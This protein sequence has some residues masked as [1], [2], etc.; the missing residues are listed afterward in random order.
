M[1][2][3]Y[4]NNPT[5]IELDDAY[6]GL[7]KFGKITVKTSN[8][9]LSIYDLEKEGFVGI[10]VVGFASEAYPDFTI[11]AFKG[12]HGPCHFTGGKAKYSGA[13]F[14]ALDD[15]NHLLFADKYQVVCDKTS[16]IYALPPY[17]DLIDC[18]EIS[19][20]TKPGNSTIEE[21]SGDF[22]SNQSFLYNQ[23]KDQKSNSEGRKSLFYPGPFRFLILNDGT[24]VRRGKWNSIP[25]S[26][27]GD[28]IR[29][30]RFIYLEGKP[31]VR[32]AFFQEEYAQF[33]S[34]CLLDDFKPEAI[35]H[36]E[37]ETDFSKLA[38]VSDKF[39]TRLLS[40]INNRKKHFILIGNDASDQ[41]G[42]CPSEEVTDA[43]KLVKYGILDALAEPVQGDSCPVTMY[44]FKDEISINNDTLSSEI[45]NKFRKKVLS[46][47][48]NSSPSGWKKAIKWVLL[49]FI[50]VSLILAAI[51]LYNMQNAVTETSMYELL[52]PAGKNQALVVLFHNRKRCFQCTRMENLTREVLA[53]SYNN[54]LKNKS[55]GFETIIID[56]PANFGIVNQYG[57]Y[58]VTVVF[59]KFDQEEVV[60]SKV[61]TEATNLYRD[62]P[63]YKN[64]LKK[65]LH[66]F[67]IGV[68]D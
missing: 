37:I 30:D 60:K 63:V 57:I 56:D 12:K 6:R 3:L 21:E 9:E 50:A 14:A 19:Q 24:M 66:Q 29:E 41:F 16:R 53:K 65:E 43:N 32:A 15:D 68:D 42:C 2:P 46:H 28:L 67:L 18:K 40:I 11:R 23:L 25:Q 4:L 51:R 22:E 27:A 64:F 35:D 52:E 39:R 58:G 62:E 33:G 5:F 54:E 47:L 44:A 59:V 61:L 20:Q 55:L 10:E 49:I 45:N 7:P 17:E 36:P 1:E 26:M 13:A 31:E 38:D 34:S 48:K 8:C